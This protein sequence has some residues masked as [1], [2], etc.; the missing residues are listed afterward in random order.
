MDAVKAH[1]R[2]AA[3]FAAQLRAVKGL[4]Q[5]LAE[6]QRAHSHAKLRIMDLVHERTG[7]GAALFTVPT[8]PRQVQKHR[9][10]M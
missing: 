1:G 7:I 4:E 2:F 10:R 3:E 6:E 8:Q 9:K 5:R